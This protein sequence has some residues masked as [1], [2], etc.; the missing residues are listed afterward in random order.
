[1]LKKTK[2]KIFHFLHKIRLNLVYK[3]DNVMSGGGISIFFMLISLVFFSFLLVLSMRFL[4]EIYYSDPNIEGTGDIIW[5]AFTQVT[6]LRSLSLD[7]SSNYTNKF[8]GIISVF[9]GMVF[10]STLVAF[11]TNQFQIK[12]TNLR[13]GKSRVIEKNH[14]LIIGFN[15][16]VFEIIEQLIYSNVNKK[17]PAI[18]IVSNTDKIQMDDMFTEEIKVRKNTRIITRSGNI[19][20]VN[21]LKKMNISKARSIIILNESN[22][23]EPIEIKDK[24]DTKVLESII[25]VVVAA[26]EDNLPIVVAQLHLK[27][28]RRL[29]ENIAPEKIL[30][31][32]T[33]E[34]LAKILVYTSLNSGLAFVYS[35]IVGYKGHE[36]CIRKFKSGWGNR[37][38]GLLQFHFI[39]SIL[40][41]FRKKTGEILLNPNIDYI[42][43]DT[44]DGIFLSYG[45]SSIKL[46]KKPVISAKEQVFFMKKSKIVLAKNL[47]VGWNEKVQTLIHEYSVS[48]MEGSIVDIVV[49]SEANYIN[50]DI[51]KAKKKY[52]SLKINLFIGDIHQQ[53][54]MTKIAPQTYNNIVIVAEES[55]GIEEV[56][57]KTISRLLEFRYFLSKFENDT[58]KTV[59]TQLVTEVI[60]SEKSDLFFKAGAKEFLIPH[61]FVSQIIAQISQEPDLK[62]L[63]DYLFEFG[64]GNEIYVK[65]AEIFFKK[66]PIKATFAD[67]IRAAQ[68]R[69]EVCLGIKIESEIYDKDKNYG[70]YLLPDK[71]IIFYL[72]DS[73]A[74]VT[75][76]KN[77]N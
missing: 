76:S 73:D 33:N 62:K 43:D 44:D 75:L 68:I 71:N 16:Q 42:P 23:A 21:F 72:A 3:F 41:G 40:M 26:K 30:I 36:I 17:N 49:H 27:R 10:F 70:L 63:Y 64:R 37:S 57:L 51:T 60:D 54:F 31:V 34:I 11:I 22:V 28:T 35:L 52:T 77:R 47:I 66:F 32:D 59:K 61:K 1:M 45:L 15:M 7:D 6:G 74:L 50:V 2:N 20:N 29:A 46:Y 14:T 4:V 58:G 38:F 12:V 9:L 56:D 53:K 13:K 8:V 69:G 25:A 39:N 55:I 5:R 67:C 48:T 24:G 18:V 19:T 65:P